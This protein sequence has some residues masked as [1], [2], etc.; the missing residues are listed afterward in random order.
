[1]WTGGVKV[2]LITVKPQVTKHLVFVYGTLRSGNA[3]AMS[4]R[5]PEAK[6]VAAAT[7]SGSLYDLGPYPGLLLGESN[8]LVVGEV[9]E[10]DDETL[11]ELDEFEA[12]SFYRRKGV[13]ISVGSDSRTGWTY[14]PDPESYSLGTL[15]P[16]GDWI[17][18]AATTEASGSES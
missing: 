5:F 3:S 8:A 1:L 7:V 17:E 10:V 16:S 6:L 11:N 13:E 18:Y 15:I 14:E 4:V 12:P 9:Y 2:V